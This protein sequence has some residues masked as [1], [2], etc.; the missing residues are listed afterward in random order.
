[1]SLH[2][3]L[4]DSEVA[5]VRVEAGDLW[6]RFSAAATVWTGTAPDEKPVVGF[7]R[8]L[9]LRLQ[10]AQ[11][12]ESQEPQFGRVAEGR[13]RLD[14]KALRTLPVPLDH[15]GPTHLELAFANRANLVATGKGLAVEFLGPTHF[16]ESLAC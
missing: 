16:M 6:I 15:A 5:S 14:A 10:G 11:I 4:S 9:V 13:V 7:S 1:M 2:L 12:L 3:T 8:G